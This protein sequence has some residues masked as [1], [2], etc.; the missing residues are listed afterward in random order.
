MIGLPRKQPEEGEAFFTKHGPVWH[1][2]ISLPAGDGALSMDTWAAIARDV[3]ERTGI[4]PA[5]DP[6]ACR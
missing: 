4:A 1:A 5:G 6:G 3:M 2:P